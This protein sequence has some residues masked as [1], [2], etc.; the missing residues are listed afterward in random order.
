MLQYKLASDLVAQ[1]EAGRGEG[2]FSTT[3]IDLRF[4]ELTAWS[5]ASDYHIVKINH[6]CPGVLRLIASGRAGIFYTYR[7]VRDIAV[8]A[9]DRAG[10]KADSL[11]QRLQQA[12]DTYYI[13]HTHE[14]LLSQQYEE[15]IGAI[16]HATGQMDAFLGLHSS[17]ETRERV[18]A[19]NRVNCGQAPSSA[20]R[21]N[22]IRTCVKKLYSA[23]AAQDHESKNLSPTSTSP[24]KRVLG[25]DAKMLER[26]LPASS[27]RQQDVMLTDD[28][29]VAVGT[30]RR[31]LSAD[32]ALRIEMRFG[33]W[34]QDAG[35][36]EITEARSP[37][38]RNYAVAS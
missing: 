32:E 4:K 16:D 14:D 36:G 37:Q 1:T 33:G 13:T 7:D 12:V 29:G 28:H 11:M 18:I 34:L 19:K 3:E 35:Y 5:K 30:W 21:R 10:L 22:R 15:L 6:P 8:G 20:E 26:M 24:K 9:R 2:H 17:P 25:T 27:R 23:L 38:R 31:E